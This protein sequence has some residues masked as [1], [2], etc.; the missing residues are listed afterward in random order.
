M[1]HRRKVSRPIEKAGISPVFKKGN[2]NDKT[3]YLTFTLKTLMSV[4]FITR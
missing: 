1:H 3:N 2:H 4:S